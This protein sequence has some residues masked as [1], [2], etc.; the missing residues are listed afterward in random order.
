MIV[1]LV[2]IG[3]FYTFSHLTDA[4]LFALLYVIFGSY[5][6]SVMIRIVIVVTPGACALAGIALNVILTSYCDS[7]VSSMTT[8]AQTTPQ[9]PPTEPTIDQ[10]DQ[11]DNTMPSPPSGLRRNT[12]NINFFMAFVVLFFIAALCG[13][14]VHHMTYVTSVA[15]SSP[16]IILMS[17]GPQGR[18]IFDDY[19]EAYSWLKHNTPENSKIL[20]WW[21]YGYQIAGMAQRTTIVDNNTR[22][23]TQIA[24]A[25]LILAAP[26]ERSYEVMR[27]YDIDYLLVVF[28]GRVGY[29]SDDMNKFLWI[30]RITAGIYPEI[31]EGN[32]YTSTGQYKI[33]NEAT[34]TLRNSMMYKMSYY[35]AKESGMYQD[36]AR[37]QIPGDFDIKFKYVEEAFTSSNWMLR[38]YR[39]KKSQ[40]YPGVMEK[41][42]I[43][44]EL[45]RV[46]GK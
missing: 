5:F 11:H 15:Y 44:Q 46:V 8:S 29:S 17:Q 7:L 9:A 3:I 45:A 23:S 4:N 43:E 40:E 21:D 26:E 20:S 31:V 25:G 18:V 13:F 38:V 39:V 37:N 34:P 36:R 32:Y 27:M 22:N 28:G 14:F 2:P 19:R 1:F 42:E 30:V 41:L 33:D 10:I 16:T 12:S 6:A 24:T 35:R